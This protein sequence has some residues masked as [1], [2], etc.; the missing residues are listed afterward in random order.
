MPQVGEIRTNPN[1]PNQKA[2]WTGSVW[3]DASGSTGQNP[4]SQSLA[5]LN[6]NAPGVAYLP[7]G[8]IKP[9]K[10]E[11]AYYR[12]WRTKD[13]QAGN[14]AISQARSGIATDRRAE[15]LL[16]RQATGGIYSVP[17]LGNVVGM[18]DPEIRELDAIQSSVARQNRQP[19]EG[20]ISDF[21]A[22]QFLAMSYGKDKPTATNKALIQARREANDAIIQRRQFGEWYQGR[23]GTLSG[24]EEAWDRY[25]QDNPIFD[26][27]GEGR[28][29]AGRQQWRQYFGAGGDARPTGAAGRTQPKP[30]WSQSLPPAQLATA[31][32]FAGST[33]AG[34]SRE[35]PFVPQTEAAF[36]K[37]PAGSWVIDDDGTL[38]QK[39]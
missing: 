21:D 5:P 33:A 12:E 37:L 22:Q 1:N 8:P 9:D 17:V 38:F 20:A 30:G 25:V 34:G 28:L 6:A 3:E 26:P 29:N 23:F 36:R 7:G 10:S 39:K 19:G 32:R 31:K 16:S 13:P 35:N 15:G 27:N 24:F 18:F 2:R 11:A 4:R 14:Q